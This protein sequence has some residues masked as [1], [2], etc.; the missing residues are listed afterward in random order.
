LNNVYTQQTTYHEN[1]FSK[2][3]SSASTHHAFKNRTPVPPNQSSN[4]SQS[5]LSTPNHNKS[6]IGD[7]TQGSSIHQ[8]IDEK[9]NRLI[10]NMKKINTNYET[11]NMKI[12]E[13]TK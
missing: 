8:S 3:T 11:L 1:K 10:Y 9:L 5:F 4:K 6:L 12:N 13:L 7:T 2:Q